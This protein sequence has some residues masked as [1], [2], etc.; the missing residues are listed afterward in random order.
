MSNDQPTRQKRP[1]EN[2]GELQV[3][4]V[5]AIAEV[6][7]EAWD[8]CANPPLNPVCEKIG[9]STPLPDQEIQSNPFLSHHFLAALETSKSVGSHSGWQVQHVLVKTAAGELMAA[10]PCYLKSH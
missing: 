5:S 10:A 3:F 8:A 2:A 9:Q 7:P 1:P 6:E 4:A